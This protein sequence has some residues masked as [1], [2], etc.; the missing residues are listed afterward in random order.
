V[1]SGKLHFGSCWSSANPTVH[2][3][4]I[5]PAASILRA[6]EQATVEK[7]SIKQDRED[8]YSG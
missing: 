6:E 2:G 4:Q 7:Q 3:I 8:K 1:F 5:K